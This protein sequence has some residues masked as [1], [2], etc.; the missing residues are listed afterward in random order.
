MEITRFVGGD[1]LTNTYLV[2]NNGQGIIIDPAGLPDILDTEIKKR[3]LDMKA[4]L[5]T[6]GHF[7]HC[8]LARYYQDKGLKIY[9]HAGDAEKLHMIKPGSYTGRYGQALAANV[10]LFGGET[11]EI[12][13]LKIEVIHTPGHS[14]GG[15]CYKIGNEVLFTGDTIF[16]LS[17]GRTDNADSDFDAIAK[18]IATLLNLQGEYTYYTGHG[19]ITS[20]NFERLY[21]PIF[22][23]AED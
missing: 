21:N 20:S 12:A 7:D 18:S 9:I 11:L 13:D 6:H 5:L 4:V 1:L 22:V 15:V 17:Y 2:S 14:A 23:D 3:K 10:I 8:E 19:E 16:K